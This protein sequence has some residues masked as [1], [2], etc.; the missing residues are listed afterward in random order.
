MFLLFVMLV[1]IEKSKPLNTVSSVV[2][3][4]WAMLCCVVLFVWLFISAAYCFDCVQHISHSGSVVGQTNPISPQ[5]VTETDP[6]LP[7]QA[8]VSLMCV[9][10]CVCSLYVCVCVC[11]MNNL[12]IKLQDISQILHPQ[13]P[14]YLCNKQTNKTFFCFF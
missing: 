9:C 2:W 7:T 6:L 4:G 11:S 8:Q 13:H 12:L 1:V 10:V 14:I 3:I 5:T